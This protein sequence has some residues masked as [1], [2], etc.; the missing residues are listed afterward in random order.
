M[1]FHRNGKKNLTAPSNELV[2]L[3][4]V[5]PWQG[6]I[7]RL[8]PFYKRRKGRRG[9]SLRM[10]VAV[11]I[12]SRLRHLSDEGVIQAI[13][14]NRYMQYFCNVPDKGLATFLNPSTL[15]R[16]RKRLGTKGMAVLE[17]VVFEQLRQAG[18]IQGDALLLYS[19]LLES[20]IIDPRD[21]RT[22]YKSFYKID[23][24]GRRQLLPT[25]GY[26]D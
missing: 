5:I 17:D 8:V 18:V 19:S 25:C 24:F 6:I 1:L 10:M 21:G 14:E 20:N 9:K 22:P 11:V 4:Q 16:F 15:C 23:Q 3:R 26:Q 13:R 12:L 2:I 7:T